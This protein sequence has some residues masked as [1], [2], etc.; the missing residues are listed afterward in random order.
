MGRAST[1]TIALTLALTAST[2]AHADTGTPVSIAIDSSGY[3]LTTVSG[4]QLLQA[5]IKR[6]AKRICGPIGVRAAGSLAQ[7]RAN[8]RCIEKSTQQ[9]VQ[10]ARVNGA[11]SDEH[12]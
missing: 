10:S 1:L 11:A 6:T 9:A 7:A 12:S 3:D 5:R 8:Q 2:A 4:Q